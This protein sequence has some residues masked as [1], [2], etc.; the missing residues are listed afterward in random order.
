ML[1]T[2]TGSHIIY[3]FTVKVAKMVENV[4]KLSRSCTQVLKDLKA[5][6][7]INTISLFTIA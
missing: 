4:M 3:I 7:E 5:I 6:I 1:D 2:C